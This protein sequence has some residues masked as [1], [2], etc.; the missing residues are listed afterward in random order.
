[1]LHLRQCLAFDIFVPQPKRRRLAREK[2]ELK[3]PSAVQYH[4]PPEPN[5]ELP[6]A[7]F[8]ILDEEGRKMVELKTGQRMCWEAYCELRTSKPSATRSFLSCWYVDYNRL[9]SDE[10][11]FKILQ[12]RLPQVRVGCAHA[13]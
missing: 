8:L 7:A 4:E 2:T 1:L 5:N 12:H 6:V 3:T 9:K 11:I 10:T 13:F